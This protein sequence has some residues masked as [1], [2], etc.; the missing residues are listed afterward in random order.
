MESYNFGIISFFTKN[1]I[2][3]PLKMKNKIESHQRIQ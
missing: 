2:K 1:I 3:E